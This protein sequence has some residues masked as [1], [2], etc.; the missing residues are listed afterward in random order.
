MSNNRSTIHRFKMKLEKTKP[1]QVTTGFQMDLVCNLSLPIDS[2]DQKTRQ[3][4]E[5]SPALIPEIASTP[6]GSSGLG[7]RARFKNLLPFNRSNRS[8]ASSSVVVSASVQTQLSQVLWKRLAYCLL[9]RRLIAARFA[10]KAGSSYTGPR[11]TY[12]K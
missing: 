9:R 5:S 6:R 1:R 11:G 10:R 12:E 7:R 4:Q 8:I 3:S 2:L